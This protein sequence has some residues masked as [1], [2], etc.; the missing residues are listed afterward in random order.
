M[1]Y[2]LKVKS[3]D[4]PFK[5]KRVNNPYWG[6]YS[7]IREFIIEPKNITGWIMQIVER[8]TCAVDRSNNIYNNN[9]KISKL[10]K[11]NINNSNE[12]YIELFR[13]VNGIMVDEKNNDVIIDDEFCC[14][15]IK[16][17]RKHENDIVVD[18]NKKTDTSGFTQ[19]ISKCYLI[20]SSRLVDNYINKFIKNEVEAANNLKSCY[21]LLLYDIFQQHICSNKWS[22]KIRISWDYNNNGKNVLE[23]LEE[24]KENV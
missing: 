16:S 7:Y 24:E 1:K 6:D 5:N 19:M 15:A 9:K 23:C 10:T 2:I 22:C 18:W 11:N 13:V 12:T 21:D 14:G 4:H 3:S 17:Y 8:T 20:K